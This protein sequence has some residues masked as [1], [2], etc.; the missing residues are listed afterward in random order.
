MT[1]RLITI[2][3]LLAALAGC[4]VVPAPAPPHVPPGHR[5]GGLHPSEAAALRNHIKHGFKNLE[6]GDCHSAQVEFAR[7][8]EIDPANPDAQVGYQEALHCG[9]A[10]RGKGRR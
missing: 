10:A 7:A 6:K 2:A 8:L 4:V 9:Q 5:P 3:M 1:S